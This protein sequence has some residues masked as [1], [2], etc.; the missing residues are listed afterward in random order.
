MYLA[1]LFFLVTQ[2]RSSNRVLF[3]ISFFVLVCRR[4]ISFPVCPCF[5]ANWHI[6]KWSQFVTTDEKSST[7][8]LSSD[9]WSH[10]CHLLHLGY[11]FVYNSGKCLY[12]SF[13]RHKQYVHIKSIKH[14]SIAMFTLRT[15]NPGVIRTRVFC[16]WGGCDV[17]I[18]KA[19]FILFSVSMY[20]KNNFNST[21]HQK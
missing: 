12:F 21:N 18:A 14:I 6:R 10:F 1:T 3:Q 9:E 20:L 5:P 17:H 16:S 15:L 7:F 19:A 4:Q 2:V 8:F 13:S 11:F